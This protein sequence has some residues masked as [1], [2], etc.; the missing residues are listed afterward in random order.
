[1]AVSDREQEHD[2]IDIHVSYTEVNKGQN[3]GGNIN[4]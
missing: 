3:K 4:L 1:M 2:D